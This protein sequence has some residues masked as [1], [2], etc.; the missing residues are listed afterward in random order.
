MPLVD[1]TTWFLEMRSLSDLRRTACPNPAASIV[2]AEIPSPELNRFLYTA[3]GQ[4]WYWIDRLEWDY[5][6]WCAWLDRPEVETWVLYVS[7]T[8]AGYVEL[9]A[10]PEGQVEVAYFGLLPRFIGQGLGGYLLG[11]GVARAWANGARRVWVHTC[12]LDGP[13]ALANYQARGFRVYDVRTEPE[14]LPEQ[15]PGPWPGAG[16]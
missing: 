10:Q 4:G 11:A 14:E 5:A 13:N 16:V 1:V 15:S 3:V 8:P 6:R 12:S 9:E 7:G 2:R